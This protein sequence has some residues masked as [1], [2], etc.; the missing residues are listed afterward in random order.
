MAP[1]EGGTAAGPPAVGRAL[2]ALAATED[3]CGP[4]FLPVLKFLPS[5][6]GRHFDQFGRLRVEGRIVQELGLCEKGVFERSPQRHERVGYKER[7][8]PWDRSHAPN[9]C[10]AE[11][12]GRGHF[13]QPKDAVGLRLVGEPHCGNLSDKLLCMCQHGGNAEVAVREP[14]MPHVGLRSALVD[15]QVDDLIARVFRTCWRS[16]ARV[17]L[18]QRVGGALVVGVGEA[19]TLGPED[20]LPVESHT[21]DFIGRYR[22]RE[23]SPRRARSVHRRA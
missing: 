20:L 4:L 1:S 18:V 16:R 3:H 7:H 21:H 12:C 8:F 9:D 17:V 5:V 10:A 19:C 15:R 2:P 11:R 6:R 13:D 22:T 14:V 23:G